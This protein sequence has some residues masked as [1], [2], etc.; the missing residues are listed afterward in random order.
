MEELRKK[1]FSL[2]LNQVWR[3]KY[4]Y[5]RLQNRKL[6]HKQSNNNNKKKKNN[7]NKFRLNKIHFETFIKRL[8]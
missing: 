4:I 1:C 5:R 3:I 7:N 2:P 6:L 8:L